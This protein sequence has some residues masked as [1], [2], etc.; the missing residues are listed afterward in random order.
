M[1][2][3]AYKYRNTI[4]DRWGEPKVVTDT[5]CMLTA[6]PLLEKEQRVFV[7]TPDGYGLRKCH[8]TQLE[9]LHGTFA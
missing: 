8:L 4:I 5:V 7:E 9:K 6:Q 2:R 1:K 3:Q